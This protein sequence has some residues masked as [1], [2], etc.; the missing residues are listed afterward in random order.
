LVEV[1]DTGRGIP[2]KDLVRIFGLFQQAGTGVKAGGTGLGLAISRKLA[3]MM[4]GEITVTSEAG[5]GSCFRFAALLK[6]SAAVG[7]RE[8]AVSRRIVGLEPATG[9]FRILVVD[10]EPANR[11]LLCTL[12]RPLA[13]FEVAEATNGVE[14]LE[15]FS[16]WSP[17]VVLMDMRMPVMDGYEATRRI[18]ATEA[19]RAT[20]IIAI[21]ASAFNNS[22]Q[23]ILAMGVDDYF[24]KPIQVAE[25]FGALGRHLDLRYVFAEETDN[26]LGQPARAPMLSAAQVALPQ[27]LVQAMRQAVERC[28]ITQLKALIVQVEKFDSNTAR[29]LRALADRYNYAELS[30]WLE[31][32]V[33]DND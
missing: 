20:K 14:A 29:R 26:H 17:Q 1:E 15:I 11:A 5:K 30:Q 7:M 28:D 18:K 27:E 33:T 3:E 32:S 6:L 24:R 2:D 19:G 25:L 10:D 9:P 13:G 8:K 31:K 22:R 16:R 4:G 12:L 23:E 21:T